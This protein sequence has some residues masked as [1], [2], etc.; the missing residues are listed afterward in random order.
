MTARSFVRLAPP[1]P[2]R[3]GFTRRADTAT[4][5][6]AP[7]LAAI[8]ADVLILGGGCMGLSLA[9]RLANTP[10]SVVI[11]E[12]RRTYTED[13][14]WSFW[15]PARHAYSD[16]VRATWQRW[17]VA[18]QGETVTRQAQDLSYQTLASERFY[19]RALSVCA[20]APNITLHT[21]VAAHTAAARRADGTVTVD[22][23]AGH[24]RARHII[25]TR[26]DPTPPPYVQ[27]F[28]GEEIVVDA[29]VFAD[30]T[31]DLMHFAPPRAE[32]IDFLYVLPFAPDRALIEMTSLGVTPPS[33]DEL[34]KTLAG[35]IAARSAGHGHSVIR[36][37]RGRLPMGRIGPGGQRNPA[38]VAA[39]LRGGAARPSTGYAFQRIQASAAHLAAQLQ[40]GET[41]TPPA[42]DGPIGAAMDRLFVEV[43]RRSPAMGPALFTAMF[44][45]AAPGRLERFL[46]GST[47]P[48][49]RLA[50]IGSLPKWPFLRA[51]V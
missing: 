45:R 8:D 36:S 42:L 46:S 22:T 27:A 29:A 40:R 38:T 34:Q 30:D 23:E 16:C 17:S 51:L 39:G 15:A 3:G 47:E 49:D 44:R 48:L 7:P 20:D 25:D 18:L 43:L 6:H 11:V 35:V 41:P 37:E 31:V 32:R 14:T 50:V 1:A 26:P 12:P 19:T 13:R 5:H 4:R 10:L 9:M 2:V 33:F 28:Y 24:L 21:G